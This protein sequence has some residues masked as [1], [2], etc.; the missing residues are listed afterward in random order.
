MNGSLLILWGNSSSQVNNFE[1]CSS[2][3]LSPTNSQEH[4]LTERFH[5]AGPPGSA[6][7]EKRQQCQLWLRTVITV[8]I[9][10][11]VVSTQKFVSN[12]YPVVPQEHHTHPFWIPKMVL[13]FNYFFTDAST[14]DSVTQNHFLKHV[15]FYVASRSLPAA[16][17][18]SST[19][20]EPPS[21]L[22]K[23][24]VL[25]GIYLRECNSLSSTAIQES[26]NA[27]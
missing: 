2:T 20:A 16:L 11:W 25:T 12:A 24:P 26:R 14:R 5:S 19:K 4:F 27:V 18:L 7:R 3:Y 23:S 9:R 22:R 8:E 6:L 1:T 10:R 17:E 13:P 21:R 15:S